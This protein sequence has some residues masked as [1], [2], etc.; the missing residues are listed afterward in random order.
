MSKTALFN[1]HA[2]RGL[3]DEFDRGLAFL[4]KFLNHSTAKS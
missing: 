3:D 1:R 4:E 2:G